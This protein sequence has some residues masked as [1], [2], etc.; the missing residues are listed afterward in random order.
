MAAMARLRSRFCG[1]TR[2]GVLLERVAQV[3]ELVVVEHHAAFHLEI[4][5]QHVAACVVGHAQPVAERVVLAQEAFALGVNE[6]S[7]SMCNF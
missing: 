6:S 5:P 3:D 7:H 1:E 4:L 2:V